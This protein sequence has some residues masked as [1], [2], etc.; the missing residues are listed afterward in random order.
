[1]NETD[2]PLKFIEKNYHL[3][4]VPAVDKFYNRAIVEKISLEDI[5]VCIQL[6]FLFKLLNSIS[7]LNTSRTGLSRKA[8]TKTLH[9]VYAHVQLIILLLNSRINVINLMKI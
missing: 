2:V 5:Y 7:E 3:K 4:I 6:I 8:Q 1:M 9:W